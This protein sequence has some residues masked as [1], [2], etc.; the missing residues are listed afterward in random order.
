MST[1]G[2]YSFLMSRDDLIK[3]SLRCTTRFGA[4]DTVP[5]EDITYC[6]QALNI[7]CKALAVDGMPLWCVQELVVP[8]VAG[9][10]QYNL[11]T[12]SGNTLPL[13]VIDCFWR[14]S[15]GNDVML[16]AIGRSDYEALGQKAS[17]GAP[18]SYWYDPQLTGGL[19]TV[20]NVPQDASASLHVIIQRQIQD[21]NLATDNVD[22]P[23]EAYQ[24]LKWILAEEI[25]LEYSTPKDVRAEIRLQ[26]ARVKETFMGSSFMQEQSSVFFTPAFRGN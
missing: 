5:T 18:N 10:A 26:A 11:S 13:R 23:Q 21:V 19:L 16:T 17:P 14:S 2:T 9:Q 8:F 4:S 1:S 25:M 7:L 15:T 24:M 6:A 3:A 22:F 12:A 20:Y